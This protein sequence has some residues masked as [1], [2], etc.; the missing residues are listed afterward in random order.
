[1]QDVVTVSDPLPTWAAAPE[2]WLSVM[3][4]NQKSAWEA[5]GQWFV[6]VPGGVQPCAFHAGADFTDPLSYTNP[7]GSYG[8]GSFPPPPEA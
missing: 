1:M 6:A 7:D 3:F 8:D 4:A 2:E 5:A